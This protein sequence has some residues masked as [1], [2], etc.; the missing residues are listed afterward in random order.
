MLAHPAIRI[1]LQLAL[2]FPIAWGFPG[3]FRSTVF[4]LAGNR[5][6]PLRQ[7][8]S[9]GASSVGDAPEEE[10]DYDALFAQRVEQ[11]GGKLGV[12][13]KAT[14]RGIARGAEERLSE[15]KK[16]ATEGAS[17]ASSALRPQ[18]DNVKAKEQGLQTNKGWDMTLISLGSVVVLALFL[19]FV[20][21]SGFDNTAP[22]SPGIERQP[23]REEQADLARLYKRAD[24]RLSQ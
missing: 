5:L 21:G 6:V 8:T 2:A 20:T 22:P 7:R 12:S 24:A 1:F 4:Q 15:A 9:I 13:A 16:V 10:V 11:D 18:I 23:T 14:A 3:S 17:R 19:P